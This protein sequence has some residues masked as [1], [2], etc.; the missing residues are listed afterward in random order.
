MN[1]VS[2]TPHQNQDE[3]DLFGNATEASLSAVTEG[4]GLPGGEMTRRAFLDF[5]SRMASAV[6]VASVLSPL[7]GC[8]SPDETL[9]RVGRE[10]PDLRDQTDSI[11]K[12]GNEPD[13]K[14]SAD[15]SDHG[16]VRCW[17]QALGSP[18]KWAKNHWA[19]LV[20][21]TI[22]GLTHLIP[23]DTWMENVLG[24]AFPAVFTIGNGVTSGASP[25]TLYSLFMLFIDKWIP[26][27][28]AFVD[29]RRA[30]GG[31]SSGG[32]AGVP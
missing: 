17:R 10:N 28:S 9:E 14:D 27:G 13:T 29:S 31:G 4:D 5:M 3:I 21:N 15:D 7:A 8:E 25:E 22:G 32:G 26:W 24:R 23:G 16:M 20:F 30:S 6:A 18:S 2:F 11:R 1:S 12:I 19:T